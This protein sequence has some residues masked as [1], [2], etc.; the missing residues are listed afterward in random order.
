MEE[1]ELLKKDIIGFNEEIKKY[2]PSSERYQNIKYNIEIAEQ[3][4]KL[5]KLRLEAYENENWKTYYESDCKLTEITLKTVLANEENYSSNLL[6]SLKTNKKYAQYRASHNLTYDERFAPT[7]GISYM[8]RV[9]NDY[10]PLILVFLSIFISSNMYSSCYENDLNIHNVIP[11]NRIKKQRDKL[12]VG[13]ICCILIF[14][15]LIAI[16][17]VCG[18]FGNELG[19]LQSPL[20]TYTLEGESIYISIISVLPQV[21]LISL[22]SIFFIVN[23]VSIISLIFKRQLTCLIVSLAV[24]LSL[25]WITT[26]IVPLYTVMHFSPTTYFFSLKIISGEL[27]NTIQNSNVTF[28]NGVIILCASNFLLFTIHYISSKFVLEKVK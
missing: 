7:Q 2:E 10:L 25:M 5:L 24:L 11:I 8:I 12:L 28:V 13:V 6:R 22:L 27:M 4:G 20:L 18:V 1:I 15:F 3:R 26:T 16:P 21:L 14:M 9:L 23:T 17:I 19:N